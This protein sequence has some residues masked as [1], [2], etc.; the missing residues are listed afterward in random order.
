MKPSIRDSAS[1]D[2]GFTKNT[3]VMCGGEESC[4]LAESQT[5]HEKI[6]IGGSDLKIVYQ[7]SLAQGYLSTLFIQLTPS[8]IPIDLRFVF[9][10]IVIEGSVTE[11][12]FEAEPELLY[13]FSWNKRNIYKQKCFGHSDTKVF[14]GY[15]YH[16]CSSV[17]WTALQAKMKGYEMDI[18][19]LGAWNLDI[20]HRYNLYDGIFQRGEGQN[21]YFQ[22]DGRGMG[23]NAVPLSLEPI[24]GSHMQARPFTCS[25]G[26]ECGASLSTVRFFALTSIDVSPDGSIYIGDANLIRRITVDGR[27]QSLYTFKL[28]DPNSGAQNGRQTFEYYVAYNSLDN[29]LYISDPVRLQIV[30][31]QM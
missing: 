30:R 16:G 28:P 29:C 19:E 8:S 31:V 5:V 3:G 21:V 18:S 20:H 11:K 9:V 12:M 4:I 13:T 17:I 1:D 22:G 15:I 2:L 7:S 24:A 25:S 23:E 6:P 27:V 26:A 14:V 10:R